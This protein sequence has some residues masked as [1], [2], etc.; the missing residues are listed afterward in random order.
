M[1]FG[2]MN[3]PP[4][5]YDINVEMVVSLGDANIP[6][7]MVVHVLDTLTTYADPLLGGRENVY[8]F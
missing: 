6:I 3:H 1:T 8:V 7:S 2:L 4:G 5:N